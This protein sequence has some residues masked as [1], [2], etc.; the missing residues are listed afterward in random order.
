[1]SGG[2]ELELGAEEVRRKIAKQSRTHHGKIDM[3]VALIDH[4]WSSPAEP[5]EPI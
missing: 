4:R 2:Q 5:L 3:V 1:M